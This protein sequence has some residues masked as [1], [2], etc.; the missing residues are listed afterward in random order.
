MD[1]M[2]QVDDALA[3]ALVLTAD[4][5]DAHPGT[6]QLEK[7]SRR[8]SGS[9]SCHILNKTDEDDELLVIDGK[10]GAVRDGFYAAF[11]HLGDVSQ[12][13]LSP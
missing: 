12:T 4:E 8:P 13:L 5:P 7:P 11:I 2:L 3:A 6:D 1:E 10:V 9:W